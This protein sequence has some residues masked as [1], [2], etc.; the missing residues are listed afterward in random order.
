MAHMDR[1][2]PVKDEFSWFRMLATLGCV[3]CIRVSILFTRR[4]LATR[5]E[6]HIAIS[7][8]GS[9]TLMYERIVLTHPRVASN[10]SL[11]WFQPDIHVHRKSRHM[12]ARRRRPIYL[13]ALRRFC[14]P[15]VQVGN[16]DIANR[17]AHTDVR[18]EARWRCGE[19][20]R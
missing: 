14:T 7:S 20:K 3:L 12:R 2:V 9:S 16:H 4:R 5:R 8:L 13:R 17:P 6:S 18:K 19:G 11:T 15:L 10:Q 1:M